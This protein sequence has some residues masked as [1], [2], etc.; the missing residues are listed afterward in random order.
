M[1]LG[2]EQLVSAVLNDWR[3]AP[4]NEKVRS[5]LEFLEKLTLSPEMV[6]A[7]DINV[8]RAV[9]INDRGIEEVIYVCFLFNVMD[10]LA[11]AFG[12]EI[13]T[14]EQAKRNGR[15]LYKQGYW[16]DSIPG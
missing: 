1:G 5:A 16:G 10:R 6:E 7:S 14:P 8:M 2:D 12:F 3:N 11:D 9:G 15:A 4:V 13:P